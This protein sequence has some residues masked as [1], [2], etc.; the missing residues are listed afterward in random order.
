MNRSA[1]RVVSDMAMVA[2]MAF[3]GIRKRRV[4]TADSLACDTNDRAHVSRI[5][6]RW[7][8]SSGAWS[9]I[10]STELTLISHRT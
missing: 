10:G 5:C 8:I 6:T 1:N 3:A 4:Q 7:A 9:G 2:T